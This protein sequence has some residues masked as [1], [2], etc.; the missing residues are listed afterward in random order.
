[1]SLQAIATALLLPP[2]LLLLI[3]MLGGLLAWRGQRWAGALAALAAALVLVLATPMAAGLLR[4]SLE[5]QVVATTA[6]PAPGAIV[7][8]SAEVAH[9]ADGPEVG[10]LTLERLRAGA[11]LHRATGLPVLVTGGPAATDEP[12]MAALMAA[13][14]LQDFA[15]P[16]RWQ[17]SR[18][19]D[20]RQNAELS[21]A[22]LRAEGVASV[23]LVTHG[24]HLPRAEAAFAR[25]GLATRSAPVRLTP[26]P[27]GRA[28]DWVPSPRQLGEAWFYLREWAGRLVYALRHGAVAVPSL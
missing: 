1:V 6:G 5:S 2:S 3:A 28:S 11:Q 16:V 4:W 22:M 19:K 9:G 27:D 17:E 10:P 8:L 14:L 12:S 23:H 26:P 15:V 13:V 24:W 18:A 7:V 20:T 25:A 21:A